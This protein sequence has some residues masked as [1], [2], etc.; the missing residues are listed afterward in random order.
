MPRLT[1]QTPST[2]PRPD[3]LWHLAL[4]EAGHVLASFFANHI[5]EKVY[6]GAPKG[7]LVVVYP[8]TPED[9]AA[10]WAA[11][12]LRWSLELMQI[13]GAL[14]SGALFEGGDTDVYGEDLAILGR[15]RDA[16]VA[17]VGSHTDWTKLYAGVYSSLLSWR[18]R[19]STQQAVKAL[20]EGLLYQGTTSREALMSL[21]SLANVQHI[22][23][24][25]YVPELPAPTRR[26]PVATAVTP[27]QDT[28][29]QR[30]HAAIQ[31]GDFV[32]TQGR[33]RQPSRAELA[34]LRQVQKD[35]HAGRI[36]P[37]LEA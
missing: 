23:G 15:W 14:R 20:A 37:G 27:S 32:D 12:P 5:I 31:A 33:P 7:Y 26:S 19:A 17:G 1:L 4:H 30:V 11:S 10:R 29:Q 36:V 18:Q 21:L 9:L 2:T 22:P 35:V 6:V 13:L 3:A 28:I 24:P 25:Y 16:Y 34:Y 8:A